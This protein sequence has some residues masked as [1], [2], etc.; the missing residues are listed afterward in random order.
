MRRS[1][2]RAAEIADLLATHAPITMR[3]TKEGLRRLRVDGA[4]ADD[5]DLVVEA[6]M[7]EDFREGMDA[8]LGKRKPQWKGR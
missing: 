2:E 5:R 3:A 1:I 6:Y 8:F 4:A 7:S